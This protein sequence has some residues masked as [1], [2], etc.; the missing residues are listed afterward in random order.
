MSAVADSSPLILFARIGQLGM[1]QALFDELL[2]PPAVY[3]EVVERGRGRPGA[4]EVAG[5]QWIRVQRPAGGATGL[6][7]LGAGEAEAIALAEERRLALLV[8]DR[9]GRAV[10]AAR[11]IEVIGSA[12]VLLTAKRRGLIVVMQPLLDELLAIGLH[13]DDGLY[14]GVLALAGE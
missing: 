13:L 7:K 12:G 6:T 9:G 4:S 5:A 11:R 1:L 8:D 10:A 3:R 14:A 2:I